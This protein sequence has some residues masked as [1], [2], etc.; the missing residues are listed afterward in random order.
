MKKS[1]FKTALF[2]ASVL[3]MSGCATQ[4]GVKNTDPQALAGEWSIVS[5]DGQPV[6]STE[7]V[8]FIG[9]NTAEKR[10]SGNSGCNLM[11][12]SYEA[13]AG[14]ITFGR[15][16]STMMMCPDMETERKVLKAVEEVKTYSIE[17]P[18]DK[19]AVLHLSNAEGK[20]IITLEKK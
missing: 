1:I 13:Q 10:V 16:M 5:V 4:K 14:K 2:T 18:K 17:N 15:M 11:N 6:T 3:I 8:P 19:P 12:G 20:S 7:K 9:F